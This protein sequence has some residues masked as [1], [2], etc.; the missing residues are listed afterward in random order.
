MPYVYKVAP[1]NP[2]IKFFLILVCTVGILLFYLICSKLANLI[3][4]VLKENIPKPII[5]IKEYPISIPY[6]ANLSFNSSFVLIYKY[7]ITI[8]IKKQNNHNL[9]I[10]LWKY[11]IK[12]KIEILNK[13]YFIFCLS[14][15]LLF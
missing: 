14:F 13:I 6:F 8:I 7:V 2:I 4:I 3:I 1:T 11:S 15:M 12:L 10:K 9:N 5:P